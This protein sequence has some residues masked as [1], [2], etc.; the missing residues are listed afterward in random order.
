MPLPKPNVGE[1]RNEFVSR[2]IIDAGMRDEFGS[3]DQRIAVCNSLYEDQKINKQVDQNWNIEFD[4][5]LTR[6]EKRSIK[7]FANY[8][9]R[10]YQKG[11]DMHLN[12]MLNQ[13]S[14][15]SIFKTDDYMNMYKN[16]Y[17]DIGM[18]MFKWSEKQYKKY[19]KKAENYDSL[20]SRMFA[21]EGLR[22]A[23]DMVTLV[24]GT[25]K[26]T[27]MN[28]IQQLSAD[29]EYQQSGARVQAQMFRD[30]FKGYSNYQAERLVRTESNYCANFA[31]EQSALAVFPAN[32][33][34]K[35]WITSIDGRERASHREANGQTRL[36]DESF[37][38]GGRKMMRPGD[39]KGGAKQVINCRCAV[40]YVPVENAQT[41]QEINDIGFGLTREIVRDDQLTIV[42]AIANNVIREELIRQVDI[43]QIARDMKGFNSMIKGIDDFP[44]EI[45]EFIDNPKSI[46]F[47]NNNNKVDVAFHRVYTYNYGLQNEFIEEL[48]SINRKYFLSED[49]E[50]LKSTIVHEISHAIHTQ[51]KWIVEKSIIN[52]NMDPIVKDLFDKYAEKRLDF[53]SSERLKELY[54]YD[55]EIHKKLGISRALYRDELLAYSDTIM[56]LTNG[57]VGDGHTQQYWKRSEGVNR[58]KEFFVHAFENKFVGNK[59]FQYLDPELYNEM[60]EMVNQYKKLL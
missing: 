57:K 17:A 52:N 4:K 7:N 19:Q 43:D 37:D 11:V 56:A 45:L 38:V 49:V 55:T 33:I 35:Q 59:T 14:L 31:N 24:Q 28:T 27:L 44:K 32:Q 50:M 1:S 58:Y 60:I 8:Y 6:A 48:I 29:A 36:M 23:G 2:C 40:L 54:K 12:G 34:K 18:K 16:M 30:K 26:K 46:T 22:Q 3:L 47:K 21:Q 53:I 9:F 15:N 39:K 42:Q 20:Y 41:I 5:V 25:A 51:K 10:E 13:S